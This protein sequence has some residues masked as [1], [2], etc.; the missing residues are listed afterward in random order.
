MSGPHRMTQRSTGAPPASTGA[1]V[2]TLADATAS[3]S[4]V[5][6]RGCPNRK[7]LASRCTLESCAAGVGLLPEP[8]KRC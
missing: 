4:L 8:K 3:F 1:S 6:D 2:H 7:P 5:S